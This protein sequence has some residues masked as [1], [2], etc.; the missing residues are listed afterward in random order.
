MSLAMVTIGG[1]TGASPSPRLRLRSFAL[2]LNARTTVEESLGKQLL[3]RFESRQEIRTQQCALQFF[4][5][6]QNEMDSE[7]LGLRYFRQ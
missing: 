3:C 6:R 1:S 5:V 7:T 4:L 2:G